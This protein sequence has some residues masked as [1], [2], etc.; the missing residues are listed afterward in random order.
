MASRGSTEDVTRTSTAPSS[1]TGSGSGTSDSSVRPNA[2]YRLDVLI[3]R[4]Q[5]SFRIHRVLRNLLDRSPHRH[6][7]RCPDAS[8]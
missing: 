1:M 2:E 8:R 5:M 3:A 7:G 4:K 6:R